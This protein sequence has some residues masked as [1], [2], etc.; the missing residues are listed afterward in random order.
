MAEREIPSIFRDALDEPAPPDPPEIGPE[1]DGGDDGHRVRFVHP[2]LML[3]SDGSIVAQDWRGTLIQ[4]WCWG[5][6]LVTGWLL[7]QGIWGWFSTLTLA[8]QVSLLVL[9]GFAVGCLIGYATD[10]RL[11]RKS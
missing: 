7:G 11:V 2:V 1:R 8:W 6:S 5:A 10:R 4:G 9:A 3:L